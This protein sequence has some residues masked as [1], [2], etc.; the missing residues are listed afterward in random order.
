MAGPAFPKMV[1]GLE[2]GCCPPAGNRSC[3]TE[4]ET[5]IKTVFRPLRHGGCEDG[6]VF[7]E[8]MQR[9]VPDGVEEIR[10]FRGLMEHLPSCPAKNPA[11]KQTARRRSLPGRGV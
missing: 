9:T 11:K 10:D 2:G 7:Y 3:I 6:P 8:V 5:M 4:G 1:E